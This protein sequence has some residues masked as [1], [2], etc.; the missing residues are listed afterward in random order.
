MLAEGGALDLD[1]LRAWCKE[2]LATY[3][4]PSLLRVV[5]DLPRNALGKVTKPPI[6][7]SLRTG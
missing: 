5:D 3:K 2:R 7:D 6:V 1:E 4:A